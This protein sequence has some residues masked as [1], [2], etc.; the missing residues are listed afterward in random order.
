MLL[1]TSPDSGQTSINVVKVM[2][3]ECSR[4]RAML[5]VES[6]VTIRTIASNQGTTT[7]LFLCL[8]PATPLLLLLAFRAT[9]T[10]SMGSPQA[11]SSKAALNNPTLLQCS[12]SLDGMFHELDA[13]TS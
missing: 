12:G 7:A 11:P 8:H 5:V 10:A 1:R 13:Y 3:K 4:E 9:T 6:D 2:T